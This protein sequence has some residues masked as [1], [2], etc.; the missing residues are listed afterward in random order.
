M[1]LRRPRRELRLAV[2]AVKRTLVREGDA[3]LGE[4]ACGG[5]GGSACEALCS[6]V[7]ILCASAKDLVERSLDEPK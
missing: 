2:G 3:G 4:T 7:A 6:L 1:V 5:D